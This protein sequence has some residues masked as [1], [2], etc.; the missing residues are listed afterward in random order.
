MCSVLISTRCGAA[1]AHLC[2]LAAAA[3]AFACPDAWYAKYGNASSR[4]FPTTFLVR[5]V[6]LRRACHACH[7]RPE[8][9]CCFYRF[10]AKAHLITSLKSALTAELPVAVTASAAEDSAWTSA[11]G[12]QEAKPTT[13]TTT[14]AMKQFSPSQFRQDDLS[15]SAGFG[16]LGGGSLPARLERL[17]WSSE[18]GISSAHGVAALFDDLLASRSVVV[19]ISSGT[20]TTSS[21]AGSEAATFADQKY[22]PDVGRENGSDGA[23]RLMNLNP[24]YPERALHPGTSVAI[25]AES[26]GPGQSFLSGS[27]LA[28]VQCVLAPQAVAE[29]APGEDDNEKQNLA[30]RNGV[31]GNSDMPLQ[32][33]TA[34]TRTIS[35]QPLL[36]GQVR[37]SN[38]LNFGEC[39][40]LSLSC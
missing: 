7:E 13:R 39:H 26:N 22:L 30:T 12:V 19:P 8:K 16:R 28:E 3:R 11:N 18:S 27:Q 23:S 36:L 40:F 29:I 6:A 14:A 38:S 2:L 37:R 21:E 17:K 31:I 35:S 10:S 32:N 34:Q 33:G 1:A 5:R 20:V 15:Q 4:N 24:Q 9:Y 25:N